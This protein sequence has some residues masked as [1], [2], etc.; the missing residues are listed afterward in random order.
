MGRDS[1]LFT[2]IV[3]G[4]GTAPACFAWVFKMHRLSCWFSLLMKVNSISTI[5]TDG[6][7]DIVCGRIVRGDFFFVASIAECSF[8]G[9]AS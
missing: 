3:P 7:S 9:K 6:S 4:T 5:R 2:R 8:H 1:V